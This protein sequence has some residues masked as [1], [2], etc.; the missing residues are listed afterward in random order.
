MITNTIFRLPI[1]KKTTWMHP[2]SKHWHLIDY[3]IV[4]Q[5]DR[6]DVRVTRAM[7]G[8][9]CW[10]DHRLIISKLNL[11]MQ[12]KKRRQGA[13]QQKKLNVECLA[14]DATKKILA[15]EISS[16]LESHD[17]PPSA[18]VEECWVDIN[19]KAYD[20]SLRILGP[21]RKMHQDWFEQNDTEIT[22]LLE[23]KHSMHKALLSDPNSQAK[24]AAY[25]TMR[26]CVQ[27]R[28]SIFYFSIVLYG[29]QNTPIEQ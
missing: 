23:K 1:H 2:R 29:F 25:N 28:L 8:A 27:K 10:T 26:S 16:A 4:R 7:C 19:Q 18:D 14:V 6:G 24:R 13:K 5:R 12:P 11:K 15:A 3:A 20:A 9:E 17:N 21:V 22:A